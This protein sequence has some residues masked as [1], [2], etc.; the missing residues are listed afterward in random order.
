MKLPHAIRLG[1]PVL[2][3]SACAGPAGE[4]VTPQRPTLSNNTHTTAAGTVEVETGAEWDPG[5]TFQTPSL[6][7][8]GAGPRT[9]LYFGWTPIVY[10]DSTLTVGPTTIGAR[11][12][13]FDGNDKAPAGA[14]EVRVDIP[15]GN[16]RLESGEMTTALA[17]MLTGH[18]QE[19]TLTGYGSLDLVSDPTDKG[20]DTGVSLA[21]EGNRLIKGKW[22]G[23][24]ELAG[25]FL[26]AQ[27]YEPIFTYFGGYYDFAQWMVFDFGFLVGLN[28]DAPDFALTF[29]LTRNFGRPSR[30]VRN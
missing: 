16:N 8:Y 6:V 2:L 22:G 9:E 13:Y 5:N 18:V 7:K 10:D 28:N 24:G 30:F 20:V 26:P 4:K 17:S 19:W 12:R 11:H 15:S 23:Y 29:G 1:L 25:Q 3:L 14:V 21:F 27:D